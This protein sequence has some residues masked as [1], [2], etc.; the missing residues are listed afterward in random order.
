MHLIENAVIAGNERERQ[1]EGARLRPVVKTPGGYV[2]QAALARGKGPHIFYPER[3]R[4]KHRA[5]QAAPGN[6]PAR[7]FAR[8][9]CSK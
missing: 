4:S 2:G 1:L 5:K 6:Y 7:C 9:F 8:R 3:G